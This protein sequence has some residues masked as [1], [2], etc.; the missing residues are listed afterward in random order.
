MQKLEATK[1]SLSRKTQEANDA[2][3]A[4]AE[5][6]KE[7]TTI[8]DRNTS[9]QRKNTSL[10]NTVNELT[11]EIATFEAQLSEQTPFVPIHSDE[12]YASEGLVEYIYDP[13]DQTES[14]PSDP[15]QELS[16]LKQTLNDIRSNLKEFEEEGSRD[17]TSLLKNLYTLLNIAELSK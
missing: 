13:T 8:K 16:I 15:H 7:L 2:Q 17:T 10:R 5:L 12:G 6:L 14:P 9:L 11:R 4:N 1:A 3:Q